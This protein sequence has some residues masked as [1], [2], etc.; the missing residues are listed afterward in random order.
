MLDLI[1]T[2]KYL[3]GVEY[4]A[5]DDCPPVGGPAPT[6]SDTETPAPTPTAT[7]Q[8]T[9]T[10]TPTPEPTAEPSPTQSPS[11]TD[12]NQCFLAIVAYHLATIQSLDG[13]QDC[14]PAA[15]VTYDCLLVRA[16]HTAACDAGDEGSPDYAC[17]FTGSA[18]AVCNGSSDPDYACFNDAGVISCIPSIAGAA[19]YDCFVIETGVSCASNVPP[20]PD[21]GCTKREGGFDCAATLPS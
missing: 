21:F 6:P 15:G 8:P 13:M 4:E 1:A 5:A 10:P 18:G 11:G 2:L 19:D 20:Y 14:V 7:A 12:V 17:D 3:G 16:E 9:P